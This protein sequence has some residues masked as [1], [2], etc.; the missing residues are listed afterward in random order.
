MEKNYEIA[1]E[2]EGKWR[3]SG[4]LC[5]CKFIILFLLFFLFF[6]C[7]VTSLGYL[8]IKST[9]GYILLDILIGIFILGLGFAA[10]LSL[11]NGAAL[12]GGRAG[13]SLQAVNLAVSTMDELD[14]SLEM[15][16]SD[17]YLF[18][19]G[20][21]SER[22][23]GLERTVR[24]EWDSPDLL[25]VTVEIKWLEGKRVREYFLESLVYVPEDGD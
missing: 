24:A 20:Q 5:K 4:K 7:G 10:V 17:S 18:L 1:F 21:P 11:L 15:R 23:G 3:K 9:K 22:I 19:A 13:L 6:D 12:A 16:S 8:Q 25:L 14:K 2:K